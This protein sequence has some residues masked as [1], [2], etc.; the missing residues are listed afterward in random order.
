MNSYT[1]LMRLPDGGAMQVTGVITFEGMEEVAKDAVFIGDNIPVYDRLD[2]PNAQG[3]IVGT[4]RAEVL[5]GRVIVHIDMEGRPAEILRRG[6]SLGSFSIA[7]PENGCD[8]SD[9]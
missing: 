4:A 3:E 2:D 1:R 8:S 7:E 6:F 5:S 9:D